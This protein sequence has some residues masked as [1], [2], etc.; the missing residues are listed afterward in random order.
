MVAR[1]ASTLVAVK[2]QCEHTF[3]L[4]PDLDTNLLSGLGLRITAYPFAAGSR[5]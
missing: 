3:E 5:A 2:F 4:R 1:P